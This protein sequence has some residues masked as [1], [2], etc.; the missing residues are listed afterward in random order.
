MKGIDKEF[1]TPTG[2]CNSSISL[3]KRSEIYRAVLPGVPSNELCKGSENQL[4]GIS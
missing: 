1:H 3:Y 2:P 4:K